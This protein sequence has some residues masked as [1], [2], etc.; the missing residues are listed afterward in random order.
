MVR[1]K[2]YEGRRVYLLM[3]SAAKG[4]RYSV[5]R[6]IGLDEPLHFMILDLEKEKRTRH[7][8]EAINLDL[9]ERIIPLG[10]DDQLP[11]LT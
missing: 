7:K 10:D 1:I 8:V 9:V 3:H 5:G 6:V 2:D 11:I 4:D